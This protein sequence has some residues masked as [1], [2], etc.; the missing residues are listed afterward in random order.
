[1][2]TKF[3]L[4][5]L[6]ALVGGFLLGGLIY[7]LIFADY[8]K[9]LMSQF[10]PGVMKEPMDIWAIICANAVQAVFITWI[11]SITQTKTFM[12]GFM[13]GIYFGLAFAMSF[14]FFMVAQMKFFTPQAFILDVL[15]STV[16]MAG[17]GGIAAFILGFEKKTA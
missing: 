6:A 10:P 15:C 17:M 12:T 14:D 11:F 8:F 9:S 5:A 16:I 7:G 3:L 1:M 13:K 4:A 2:N